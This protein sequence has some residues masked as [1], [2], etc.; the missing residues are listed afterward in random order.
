L[1]AVAVV[2]A[3]DADDDVEDIGEKVAE[4]R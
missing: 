3:G 4:L 1:A 2:D